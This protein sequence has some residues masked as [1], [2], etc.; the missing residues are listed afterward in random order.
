MFWG[1][2]HKR[3]A[4]KSQQYFHF[5]DIRPPDFS[6]EPPMFCD[7][8]ALEHA[9][10]YCETSTQIRETSEVSRCLQGT[11]QHELQGV[12]HLQQCSV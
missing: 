11:S 9:L 8:A 6:K 5:H 10:P 1:L 4:I 7:P 2:T 3:N 12:L